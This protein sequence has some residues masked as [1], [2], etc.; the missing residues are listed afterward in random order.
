MNYVPPFEIIRSMLNLT[1]V[2][3]ETRVAMSY[4]QMQQ[5]IR[6]LIAGI[7]VDEAW[8]LTRNPDVGEGIKAGTI[9]SAREHFIDHGFFEG[10]QPF[11][12]M[13]DERFYLEHN[14]DVAETVRNGT[15]ASAQ[16]H[17]DGPGYREGR[18]PFPLS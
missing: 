11:P 17:F 16:E 9:A 15:Y 7:K 8:Y 1:T 10:R 18:P 3:G 13:I 2:R 6:T 14:P 4:D 5:M 12:I